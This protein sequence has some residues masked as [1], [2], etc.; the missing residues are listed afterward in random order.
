[1]K[2]NTNYFFKYEDMFNIYNLITKINPYYR[3]YY[4]T[5]ERTY[6]I[7][8]INNNFEICYCFKSFF[9]NILHDL[10]FYKIEN[11]KNILEKIEY[12]NSKLYERHINNITE[13]TLDEIKEKQSVLNHSKI[14]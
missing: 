4:N 2:F 9:S 1:M 7:V 14:F 12:E 8:N 3:L 11:M 13:K 6:C 5:K 10:R